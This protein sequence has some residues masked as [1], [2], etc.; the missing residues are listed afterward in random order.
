M[1]TLKNHYLLYF[2]IFL[3]LIILTVIISNLD[4]DL[5]LQRLFYQ[6]DSPQPWYQK[7]YPLWSWLYHYG[8][9][10][11]IIMTLIAV[12]LLIV[13]YFKSNYLKF[14]KYSLLILLTLI[15]GP[16]LIINGIL[17]DH[18]GRPRPRQIQEFGGNWEF[19]E[20]WQQGIPGKGKS[21]PCGHCSM[22]FIFIVLYF[23]FKQKNRIIARSSFAFSL[24]YGALIGMARIA[25]G[26]H[27]LSD[28]LWA[29]GITYFTAAFLYYNVLKILLTK[30]DETIQIKSTARA[31]KNIQKKFLMIFFL[32]GALTLLI[33][34]FLFSKPVF[35]EYRDSVKA[36]AD[37]NYIQLI[38][39]M[40]CAA[41]ISLLPDRSANPVSVEAVIQGFGYPKYQFQNQ[42]LKNYQHDTLEV[43]YNLLT[44]GF[45]YELDVAVKI[46]IDT[47]AVILLSGNIPKSELVI[48]EKIPKHKLHIEKDLITSFAVTKK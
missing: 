29:G 24:C 14:R 10:P 12:T 46:Y 22:G 5:K 9:I 37:F 32:V 25:Q 27:F 6:Q 48:N 39:N 41:T 23:S 8:P 47:S 4:W 43:R 31:E 16:G 21:F 30:I 7:N 3:F 18:W 26:G 33:F 13:G 17:K 35:K 15:L 38:L 11:A 1:R 42:L 44:N 28:V 20:I 40:D 45:F 19:R 2:C 36:E 34:F